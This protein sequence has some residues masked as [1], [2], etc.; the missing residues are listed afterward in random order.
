M[1]GSF[2]LDFDWD[3]PLT[4]KHLYA[5][6]WS[7]DAAALRRNVQRHVLYQQLDIVSPQA[8]KLLDAA[9]IPSYNSTMTLSPSDLIALILDHPEGLC[10]AIAAAKPPLVRIDSTQGIHHAILHRIDTCVSATFR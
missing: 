2:V 3:A 10:L 7:K 9:A 8:E 4:E 6:E 1:A 5:W